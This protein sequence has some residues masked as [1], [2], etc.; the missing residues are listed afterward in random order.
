MC[1]MIWLVFLMP[2]VTSC[3]PSK[4]VV[5]KVDHTST[6]SVRITK[7]EPLA[8]PIITIHN[9][10]RSELRVW[11]DG[12]SWGWWN[13]SFCVAMD[14]GHVIHLQRSKSMSFTANGPGWEAIAP[15]KEVTRNEIDFH[16]GYWEL[17]KDL[18]LGKVRYISVIYFVKPTKES[19]EK[20][21]WTGMVVSPWVANKRVGAEEIRGDKGATAPKPRPK[22]KPQ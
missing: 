5:E 1:K 19:T 14:D 4:D 17:P 11:Q 18:N 7:A 3:A 8:R 9:D 16:D 2:F 15:D 10:T 6:V 13:V 20:G 21:V 22:P 12:N